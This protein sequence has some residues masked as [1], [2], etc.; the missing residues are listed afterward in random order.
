MAPW[1]FAMASDAP[2]TLG[3]LI[4]LVRRAI[5]DGWSNDEI[6]ALAEPHWDVTT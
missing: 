5:E 1:V 6:L 4:V 3:A 2:S